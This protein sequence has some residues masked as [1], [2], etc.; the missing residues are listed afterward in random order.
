MTLTEPSGQ[1]NNQKLDVH[2]G[3]LLNL[4][5]QTCLCVSFAFFRIH[6]K[7]PVSLEIGSHHQNANPPTC[8]HP[9]GWEASNVK[10]PHEMR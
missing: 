6:V 2:P 1:E 10:G 4:F 3:G 9:V 5:H 7:Y 8:H